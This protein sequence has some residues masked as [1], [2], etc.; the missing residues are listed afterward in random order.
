MRKLRLL[1][2]VFFLV[3]FAIFMGTNIHEYLTSDYVAPVI[4]A[5]SDV[6]HVSVTA[7]EKELLAGMTAADN[8]D[9]DVT[10]SLVVVSQSRF[11]AQNTRRINYAA[12]DENNNVGTYTRDVVYTDYHSPRFVLKEPLRFVAGN[13]SYDYFR[14]LQ[15]EDCLDGNLTSQVKITF[16]DTNMVSDSVSMQK[17]NLQVTNSAGDTVNLVLNATFEDYESYSKASPALTDYIV[18]TQKGKKL[19]LRAYLDGIW[20]AGNHRKFS[21]LGFDPETDISINDSRINYGVPG[22]YT[23]TYRLTK[24]FPDGNG[25]VSRT[26]FGT[27][28]LF[29]VVE[30]AA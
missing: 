12:F 6:L 7:S 19:E 15:A 8:L 11:V 1:L 23:V 21:D 13:S 24:G 20:T 14:H 3:V 9:G 25:G 4:T 26:D 28:T 5:E 30:D 16:G 17:V 18:Y 27:A 10:E 2:L 22:V 29:V